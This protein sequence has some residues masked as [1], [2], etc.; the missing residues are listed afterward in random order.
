VLSYSKAGLRGPEV[1]L[2]SVRLA[3]AIEAVLVPESVNLEQVKIDVADDVYVSADKDL[4]ERAIS[5]LIRNGIRYAASA[6]Q[7]EVTATPSDSV[8]VLRV[9]DSGPGIPEQDLNRIFDP[10]YRP[11]F[12]R[13][14]NTGGVGLG[15]AIVKS[16]VD[17]CNGTVICRN[18]LGKGFEVEMR[19]RAA[20]PLLATT[21]RTREQVKS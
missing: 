5:N 2:S 14:R 20:E 17:A 1:K 11:E 12:A 16:C 3:D 10:F 19:L 4:L 13:D 9:A 21:T 15:L 18:R 8:I 6:G 7:I